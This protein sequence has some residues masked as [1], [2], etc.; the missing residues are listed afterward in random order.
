MGCSQAKRCV[1]D[2]QQVGPSPSVVKPTVDTESRGYATPVGPSPSV[3]KPTVDTE[4]RGYATPVERNAVKQ[5]SDFA[6]QKSVVVSVERKTKSDSLGI[7]IAPGGP[8]HFMIDTLQSSGLIP[9]WNNHH[10]NRPELQVKEGDFVD[11]VNGIRG[12]LDVM[13]REFRKKKVVLTVK[14]FVPSANS[15]MFEARQFEAPVVPTVSDNPPLSAPFPTRGI[16]RLQGK[17]RDNI[18][19]LPRKAVSG[20]DSDA[21]I[22]VVSLD[23]IAE[24]NKSTRPC[25]GWLCFFV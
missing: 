2:E 25:G 8:V 3:V 9:E 19:Q 23:L 13:L 21:D 17:V 15:M 10:L 20:A 16:P 14:S 4:S 12:N 11:S 5:V 1:V 6:V 24:E 22:R 18:V 7:V